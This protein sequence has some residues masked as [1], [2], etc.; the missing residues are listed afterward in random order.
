MKTIG[1]KLV[2]KCNF[3]LKKINDRLAKNAQKG[4][5]KVRMKK[6]AYK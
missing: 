1:E 6:E 2:K 5:N 3:S 4:Y